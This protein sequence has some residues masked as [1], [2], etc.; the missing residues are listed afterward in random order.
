MRAT[1]Q[2]FLGQRQQIPPM[3]SA[4]KY[5]GIP[6]Y[7]YARQGQMINRVPRTIYINQIELLSL[8]GHLF[9]L[10]AEVSKGTYIRTLVEDIGLAVGSCAHVQALH[11]LS[12]SGFESDTMSSLFELAVSNA[13]EK[14]K[15]CLPIERAVEH[16]KAISISPAQKQS[17]YQGKTIKWDHPLESCQTVSL[18]DEHAH[19]IGVGQYHPE[20]LLSVR[21]LRGV[22]AS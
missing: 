5:K 4:L 12:I 19:F 1:L 16:M 22:Y 21:K 15:K 18:W 9:T 14:Y 17:L 13:M 7:H 10:R 8:H 2:Q 20:G 3:Y 6:L 11:R